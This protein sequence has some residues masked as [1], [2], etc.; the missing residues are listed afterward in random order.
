V[1]PFAS[2]FRRLGKA[3]RLPPGALLGAARAWLLLL[4]V[5]LGLRLFSFRRVQAWAQ[6]SGGNR[7]SLA[8]AAEAR[9]R[10]RQLSE[11]VDRAA[12]HHLVPMRCLRRTLALQWLLGRAGI[13]STLRIGV[14]KE[15]GRLL[16]HA[17]LEKDGLPLTEPQAV[18]DRF[19]PLEPFQSL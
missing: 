5:D 8:S 14:R 12:D 18:T 3:R 16:A 9:A 17:W 19:V 7:R 1:S 13:A 4:A 15:A 10:V 11:Q 2:F 6:R